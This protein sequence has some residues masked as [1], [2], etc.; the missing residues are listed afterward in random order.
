M[1]LKALKQ[2]IDPLFVKASSVDVEALIHEM[3]RRGTDEIS[4]SIEQRSRSIAHHYIQK[5]IARH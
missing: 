5:Y 1:Y 4:I 2:S 3:R